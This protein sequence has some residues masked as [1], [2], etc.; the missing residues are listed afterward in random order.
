MFQW[1]VEDLLRR[2]KKEKGGGKNLLTFE[3]LK[4]RGRFLACGVSLE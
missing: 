2:V 1:R 4:T 3:V